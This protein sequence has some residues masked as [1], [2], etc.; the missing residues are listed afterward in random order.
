MAAASARARVHAQESSR[1]PSYLAPDLMVRGHIRTNGTVELDGYVDGT[2]DGTCVIVGPNGK[3][4]AT[5]LAG[6]ARVCGVMRGLVKAR[7]AVFEDGC[8]FDGEIQYESLGME[9]EAQVNATLVPVLG[10]NSVPFVAHDMPKSLPRRHP[11]ARPADA[12]AEAST[13]SGS[14][15]RTSPSRVVTALKVVGGVGLAAAATVVGVLFVS[16]LLQD[17]RGNITALLEQSRV[18]P[19]PQ[20]AAAPPLP[21]EP[22][23]AAPDPVSSD[24]ATPDP[25]SPTAAAEPTPVVPTPVEPAPQTAALP[26]VPPVAGQDAAGQEE[27][28]VDPET[29]WA[30]IDMAAM[31]EDIIVS[32]AAPKPLVPGATEAEEPVPVE[33]ETVVAE[34]P[35]PPA[36]ATEELAEAVPSGEAEAPVLPEAEPEQDA[37]AETASGLVP[38]APTEPVSEQPVSEQVAALNPTAEATAEEP[39]AEEL[40]S[41]VPTEEQAATALEEES[42]ATPSTGGPPIPAPTPLALRTTPPLPLDAVPPRTPTTAPAAATASPPVRAGSSAGGECTWVQQCGQDPANPDRCVSVRHCP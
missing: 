5:I 39:G 28:V 22:V 25:V 1:R 37:G 40:E 42:D 8:D 33:E 13:E 4:R 38:E 41:P 31:E 30:P 36:P 7:A 9:P 18:S 15:E 2:V 14:S 6:E 21:A 3:V 24:P 10:G 19:P 16:P 29:P 34:E 12:E 11:S 35:E 23:A 27:Q 17:L 20:V 32:L 26:V